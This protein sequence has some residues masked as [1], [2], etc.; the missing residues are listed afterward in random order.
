MIILEEVA[1]RTKDDKFNGLTLRHPQTA[2]THSTST[3]SLLPDYATSEAQHQR[4]VSI[5]SSKFKLDPKS[6]RAALIALCVYIFLTLTI[7]VPIIVLKSKESKQHNQYRQ[8]PPSLAWP[9][10]FT[11][12]PIKMAF[13]APPPNE[14]MT[15]CNIWQTDLNSPN[16]VKTS[17]QLLPS[18]SI[19]IRSNVTH[20]YITSDQLNGTLSVSM[21]DDSKETSI[22][23]TVEMQS[24]SKDIR[25]RTSICFNKEGANKGLSIFIPSDI[26]DDDNLVIDIYVLLPRVNSKIDIF[27]TDL[28][29]FSQNFGDLS[30]NLSFGKF[31]LGGSYR[32][33]NS[34]Y[35]H[36]SQIVVTNYLSS[37]EGS[38]NVTQ[39]LSLRSSIG[40][41]IADI[42]LSPTCDQ[43]QPT[44]LILDTGNSTLNASITLNALTTTSIPTYS[45]NFAA[46]VTNFGPIQIDVA[47]GNTSLN[48]PFQMSVQN[49]AAPSNISMDGIFN[50]YF[51]AQAKLSQVFV[52]DNLKNTSRTIDYRT[53]LPDNVMGRVSKDSDPPDPPDKCH[54]YINIVSVLGPV[55]LTFGP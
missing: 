45:P 54:S 17:F 48:S 5:P 22:L 40:P 6:W 2:H 37:I 42:V 27:T 7:A 26:D 24:S 30:Q 50:G 11:N 35:L 44:I 53:S 38:F 36:A 46:Q 43:T 25:D 20:N 55:N 41:I 3:P 9:V 52:Q 31:S 19:T 16:S 15:T 33:I 51:N 14:T 13:G 34:T 4:D 1:E 32:L 12:S 29:L 23:F 49:Y 8:P 21:N 10:D 47:Y 28:P 18:D 39:S